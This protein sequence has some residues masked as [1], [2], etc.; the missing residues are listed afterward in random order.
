MTPAERAAVHF[1]Q[2][3]HLVM[4]MAG[5]APDAGAPTERDDDADGCGSIRGLAKG[6]EGAGLRTIGAPYAQ[7]RAERDAE[8]RKAAEQAGGRPRVKSS[9]PDCTPDHRDE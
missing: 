1:A 4:G 5:E 8:S 7:G 9:V 6:Q 2:A 3:L